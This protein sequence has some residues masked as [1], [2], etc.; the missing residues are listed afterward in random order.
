M[1]FI[2]ECLQICYNIKMSPPS[3]GFNRP[4]ISQPWGLRVYRPLATDTITDLGIYGDKLRDATVQMG[5]RGV[6]AL[7]SRLAEPANI[8]HVFGHQDI[9]EPWRIKQP[10]NKIANTIAEHLGI[11][12]P[13]LLDPHELPSNEMS[14]GPEEL[15]PWTRIVGGVTLFGVGIIL[16][17]EKLR[18]DSISITDAIGE[19]APIETP[20]LH[21]D[22]HIALGAYHGTTESTPFV[23]AWHRL[24]ESNDNPPTITVGAIGIQYS[25]R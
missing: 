19:L 9:T 7:N 2:A 23:R 14:F 4:H 12:S 8:L 1:V 5:G 25:D 15:E 24:I 21:F 16:D 13:H 10:G 3:L 20:S 22:P 6:L 11:Q 18:A 17:N